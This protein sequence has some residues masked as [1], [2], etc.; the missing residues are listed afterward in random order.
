[1][2]AFGAGG[3]TVGHTTDW[4]AFRDELA[5]AQARFSQ[6]DSGG[7]KDLYSHGDNA[8]IFG[9]WSE[10]ERGWTQVGPRLDWTASNNS[11]GHHEDECLVEQ[12]GEAF[13]YTVQ[14]E[15]IRGATNPR[16]GRDASMDLRVTMVYRREA[17]AWRI[18]H[19]QADPMVN[20]EPPS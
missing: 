4:S 11:G 12:V 14:I 1:V 5:A 10:L 18:V 3:E 8:S 13:A 2:E 17:G 9:G 15:R 6:G 19:R 20:I 7:M 16:T